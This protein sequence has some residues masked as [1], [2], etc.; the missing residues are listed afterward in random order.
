M[1]LNALALDKTWAGPGET[2]GVRCLANDPTALRSRSRDGVD[3]DP[4]RAAI[5]DQHIAAN[6]GEINWEGWEIWAFTH[7]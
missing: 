2:E 3:T 6:T 5:E 7:V 1:I 4:A